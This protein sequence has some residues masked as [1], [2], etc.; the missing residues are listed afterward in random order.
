MGEKQ[1]PWSDLQGVPEMEWRRV[2]TE[3]VGGNG[4][5]P[6]WE[7]GPQPAQAMKCQCLGQR[8]KLRCR[9]VK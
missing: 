1:S 7:Q 4:G 5:S 2:H 3:L 8:G 9:V 6:W